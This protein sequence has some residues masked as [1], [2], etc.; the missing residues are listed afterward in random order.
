MKKQADAAALNATDKNI[1][2]VLA[3]FPASYELRRA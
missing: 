3:W 2:A 1:T